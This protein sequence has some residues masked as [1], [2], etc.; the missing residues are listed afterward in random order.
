M[1]KVLCFH[2]FRFNFGY[3]PWVWLLQFVFESLLSSFWDRALFIFGTNHSSIWFMNAEKV[4]KSFTFVEDVI[5]YKVI[6]LTAGVYSKADFQEG[7]LVLKD[8]MLVGAQHSSNKVSEYVNVCCTIVL[9]VVNFYIQWV[10]SIFL[11][12]WKIDCLVCSFCF[13]FI[14]SIELQIGRKLYLE[15]LGVSAVDDC[16]LSDETGCTSSSGKTRLSHDTIQSLMN[17]NL[18]LPY[19]KNFPLPSVVPCLGGCKE[20]YYC[21]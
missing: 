2:Y 18:R 1:E 6:I 5:S 9:C 8:Q 10:T 12:C 16:G 21:R 20:A 3:F 13:Q 4:F 7:D 19:S 14:G 15:E 17:G 11:V